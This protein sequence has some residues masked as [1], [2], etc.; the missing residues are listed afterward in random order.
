MPH[1]TISPL[2]TEVC[3]AII[4]EYNDEV[5]ACPSTQADWRNVV[6]RVGARRNFHNALG[7]I[8][9]THIA[10]SKLRKNSGSIS[11]RGGVGGGVVTGDQLLVH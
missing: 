1:N 7:A 6:E 3:Q 4:D 2:I 9:I 5:I 11:F 8:G 10:L